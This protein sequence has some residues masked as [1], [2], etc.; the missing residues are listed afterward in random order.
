MGHPAARVGLGQG[1]PLA[2]PNLHVL[3]KLLT[4]P[5]CVNYIGNTG[6]MKGLGRSPAKK[7]RPSPI[8]VTTRRPPAQQSCPA[9]WPGS[10]GLERTVS[11]DPKD[12]A[13]ASAKPAYT[14]IKQKH[15]RWW[16]VRDPED[17]LVCLTVYPK[18]AREV[19][20]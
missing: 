16:E 9:G 18:G 10:R 4:H 12:P 14:I 6:Q 20:R 2:P 5:P 7:A 8:H 3:P 19:V 11:D 13:P 15:S 1:F 17:E